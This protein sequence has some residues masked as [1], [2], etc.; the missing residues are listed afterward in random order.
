MVRYTDRS[1]MTLDVYR[2]SKTTTQQILLSRA[3]KYV[4]EKTVVDRL[5]NSHLVVIAST[6]C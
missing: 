3:L 6:K 2:K 4:W 5:V 1:D